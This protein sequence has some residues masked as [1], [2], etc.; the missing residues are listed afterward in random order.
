MH[1]RRHLVKEEDKTINHKN[2]DNVGS[3]SNN[4]SV[5]SLI[6]K[7]DFLGA[8]TLIEFERE[9]RKKNDSSNDNDNNNISELENLA[10]CHFHLGHYDK[11]ISIYSDLYSS[12]SSDAIYN[13][14]I[15][16][17]YYHLGKYKLCISYLNKSPKN[18]L[19]NRLSLHLSYNYYNDE[20]LIIKNIKNLSEYSIFDQ[21]S[22]ASIY[23]AR[24]KYQNATDI[25]K[26]EWIKNKKLHIAIQI[27]V[28][29]CFFELDRFDTSNDILSPYLISY[30]LSIIGLNLKSCNNYRLYNGKV[31]EQDIKPILDIIQIT[32]CDNPFFSII[33]HNLC[34]FR[35]G[36]NA[37]EIL[38][39]LLNIINEAR[40][41]LCIYH[42]KN[43]QYI[44]AYS[45]ISKYIIKPSSAIEYILKAIVCC[46]IGQIKQ[47]DYE[48]KIA[49]KYFKLI[50]NS[51]SECDTIPGRQ[52]MASYHILNKS[53]NDVLIYLESIKDYIGLTQ[54]SLDCFNFNYGLSLSH[55]NQFK[56][57]EN[58]LLL[59]QNPLYKLE[60]I[61]LSHLCR[62]YIMNG[63]P[64]ESWNLYLST[65]SQQQQ[66][67][68]NNNKD[69]DINFNLLYLIAHDCYKVGQFYYSAKA[70]CTLESIE[71]TT[72]YWNGKRG[73]CCG[74]F[75]QV[76]AGKEMKEHLL[77]IMSM[78]TNDTNPQSNFILRVMRQWSNQNGIHDY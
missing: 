68:S 23:F 7:R 37:L 61:Y 73:A 19:F 31:A 38:P 17:C 6:D 62:C 56:Q 65:S 42:L 57:A 51:S 10:Y 47:S 77:D 39:P 27:Y 63:R 13:L 4:Y 29:Y 15:A 50:G 21:L 71:P 40:L 35:D 18:G 66:S 3:G 16:C 30:P 49:L 52:S 2:N 14:F 5:S 74:L 12:E 32:N 78:L 36:E 43:E 8:I 1:Y 48:L 34:V 72:E 24:N 45:I 20:N 44:E 28:A 58:V 46:C 54:Q 11:S 70:F 55:C 67:Q 64:W 69:K 33:S 60:Y 76:I 9:R 25:Y 59:I 26:K 41:N 75:Q 53:F 22:L